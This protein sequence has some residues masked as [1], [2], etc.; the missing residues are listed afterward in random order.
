M[1]PPNSTGPSVNRD[2]GVA[3]ALRRQQQQLPQ[4]PQQQRQHQHN[5]HA[6]QQQPRQASASA[7]SSVSV[8]ARSN[9][10][11][12]RQRRRPWWHDLGIGLSLYLCC[13]YLPTLWSLLS[14]FYHSIWCPFANKT[15]TRQLGADAAWTDVGIILVLSISLAIVRIVLVQYLVDFMQSPHHVEAMVR[16]KSIHLL[17]SA[18]PQSLTPTPDRKKIVNIIGTGGGP[19]LPSLPLLSNNDLPPVSSLGL[20]QQI[21]DQQQQEEDG[22]LQPRM[23]NSPS[24]ARMKRSPS[25]VERYVSYFK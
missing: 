9:V 14:Y 25:W 22:T 24:Q 23:A 10:K 3:I 8:S 13:I 16:C 2:I 15:L 20:L 4:S 12:R 5:Q 1:M 6:Q 21:Q 17:S 7:S 19:S 11:R 18:Y